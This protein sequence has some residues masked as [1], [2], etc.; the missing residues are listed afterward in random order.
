[1]A[2]KRYKEFEQVN[3]C[4][5]NGLMDE[6]EKLKRDCK[7][8]IEVNNDQYDYTKSRDAEIEKLNKKYKYWYW[9][10]KECNEALKDDKL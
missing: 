6:V 5:A 1:M 3:G 7:N 8:L 10:W 9:M 2:D 4:V